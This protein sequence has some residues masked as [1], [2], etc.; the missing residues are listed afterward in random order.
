VRFARLLFL[1]LLPLVLLVEARAQQPPRVGLIDFYGLNKLSRDK[2]LKELKLR[3]G[4]PLPASKGDLEEQIESIKGVLAANVEAVCCVNSQVILYVGVQESGAPGLELR[5]PAEGSGVPLLPDRLRDAYRKLL[6]AMASAAAKGDTAEDL[7]RGY[8]LLADED[9]RRQQLV[10]LELADSNLDPLR[11]AL[12]DGDEEERAIAAYAIAYVQDKAAVIAEVQSALRDPAPGVRANAMRTLAAFFQYA[13]SAPVPLKVETTWLV[14]S[15]H[16]VI[17]ADRRNALA[18]LERM[19]ESRPEQLMAHLRERAVDPLA[20]M[21]RWKHLPHALPAFLIL[22]RAA[23]WT[24][25]Q[26]Q[27]AWK[28]GDRDASVQKMIKALPKRPV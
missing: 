3:E 4:D 8:S 17:F 13:Q 28:S 26:T 2:L 22:G 27:E 11:K 7:S 24:D 16:S 20:E 6:A 19:T 10:F 18:Q 12:R 9:S 1:L 23:G 21:A 14:E 25:E 5:P 15:L